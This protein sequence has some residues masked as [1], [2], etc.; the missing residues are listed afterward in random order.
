[1]NTAVAVFLKDSEW[2]EGKQ[3]KYAGWKVRFTDLPEYIKDKEKWE[4]VLDD[5]GCGEIGYFS[6]YS[7]IKNQMR[8]NLTLLNTDDEEE[9]TYDFTVPHA[10]GKVHCDVDLADGGV[11]V[12]AP[13]LNLELAYDPAVV[14]WEVSVG[15]E[16]NQFYEGGFY[17]MYWD[18][19]VPLD[20]SLNKK[21]RF[22]KELER[23]FNQHNFI[24]VDES[25]NYKI[26]DDISGVFAYN[27]LTATGK[28]TINVSNDFIEQT[29]E[30]FVSHFN[31]QKKHLYELVLTGFL[32]NGTIQHQIECE[33]TITRASVDSKE[34]D[35][36]YKGTGTYALLADVVS[37]VTGYDIDPLLYGDGKTPV[38]QAVA[39][40]NLITKEITTDGTVTLKYS[41]KLK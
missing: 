27:G 18:E 26:G 13:H 31:T 17:G 11:E 8:C 1:M 23:F 28:F 10:K 32:L 15:Y 19:S 24:T 29:P 33:Y 6:A 36:T 3:S 39:V 4:C 38:E 20:N 5:K 14:E 21:A 9:S 2:E 16:N 37:R 12:E 25:G 30:Q 40:E 41:T 34:Y 35:V 7:L 22:Q